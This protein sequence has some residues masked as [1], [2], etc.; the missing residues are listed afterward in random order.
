MSNKHRYVKHEFLQVNMVD[1]FLLSFEMV[2][3]FNYTQLQSY[4]SQINDA[5][6][7]NCFL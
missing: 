4:Y 6:I 3:A 7:H 2:C 5:I 1:S